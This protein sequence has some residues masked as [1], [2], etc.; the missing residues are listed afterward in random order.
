MRSEIFEINAG[1]NLFS[2]LINFHH[3]Y[4]KTNLLERNK[5]KIFGINAG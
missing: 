4:N 5:S 1:K 3:V 2:Q